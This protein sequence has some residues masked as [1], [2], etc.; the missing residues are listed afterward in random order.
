MATTEAKKDWFTPLEIQNIKVALREI[1]K[2]GIN[3]GSY[4]TSNEQMKAFFD[5]AKVWR[6][7]KIIIQTLY[8][9]RLASGKMFLTDTDG[10]EY[11]VVRR[12]EV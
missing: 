8:I 9:Q 1:S 4:S 3:I 11:K 2:I 10:N 7:I 6:V 5:K 12:D